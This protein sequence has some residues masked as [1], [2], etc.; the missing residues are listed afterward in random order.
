[1]HRNL[2]VVAL[3][4]TGLTGCQP[5]TNVSQPVEPWAVPAMP[6]HDLGPLNP[7]NPPPDM[8]RAVSNYGFQDARSARSDAVQ[9]MLYQQAMSG[10][11]PL[12]IGAFTGSMRSGRSG[13]A[14]QRRTATIRSSIR[15]QLRPRERSPS[16]PGSC[17]PVTTGPP[18]SRRS[19]LWPGRSTHRTSTSRRCDGTS[20]SRG[21]SRDRRTATR[22]GRQHRYSWCRRWARHDAGRLQQALAPRLDGLSRRLGRAVQPL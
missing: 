4:V 12:P 20:M 9:A 18:T 11:T 7:S 13:S 5:M 17:S 8:A 3:V 21:R 10:D 16:R 19:T 15:W 2:I 6:Q 1:M 22:L 14:S